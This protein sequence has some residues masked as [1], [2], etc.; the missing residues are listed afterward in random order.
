MH[1]EKDALQ[2]I[3]GNQTVFSG[4]DL[5]K[6]NCYSLKENLVNINKQ[7]SELLFN[8]DFVNHNFIE[9]LKKRYANRLQVF[10]IQSQQDKFEIQ[11]EEKNLAFRS[12]RKSFVKSPKSSHNV[13]TDFLI[14]PEKAYRTPIAIHIRVI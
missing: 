13:E 10:S 12:A 2:K 14:I 3:L 11:E 5:R 1:K 9:L 8:A 4:D 7:Y 6:L